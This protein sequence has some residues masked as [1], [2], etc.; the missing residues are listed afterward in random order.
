MQKRLTM[1]DVNL[2]APIYDPPKS[3][4]VAGLYDPSFV[5]IE[6]LNES[7]PSWTQKFTLPLDLLT[8]RS[9]YFKGLFEGGF[10]ESQQGYVKLRN[11]SPWV[12]RIFVGWLYCQNIFYNVESKQPRQFV[13]Q[14]QPASMKIKAVKRKAKETVTSRKVQKRVVGGSA[15]EQ[16]AE[17]EDDTSSSELSDYTE[18]ESSE[19]EELQTNPKKPL[20]KRVKPQP[21]PSRR[22]Q[23]GGNKNKYNQTEDIAYGDDTTAAMYD[24]GTSGPASSTSFR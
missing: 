2:S 15:A 16:R 22:H 14:P 19:S 20:P 3:I 1:E 13:R 12:F 10:A 9:A 6:V 24:T 18:D 4:S 8:V 23:P 17:E 11:V 7:N 5:T 21:P